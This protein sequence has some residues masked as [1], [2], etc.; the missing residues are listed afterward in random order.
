MQELK[1]NTGIREQ[2]A[3]FAA[4]VSSKPQ[5]PDHPNPIQKQVILPFRIGILFVSVGAAIGVAVMW[6][7]ITLWNA[8]GAVAFSLL[9]ATAILLGVATPI[10]IVLIVDTIYKMRYQHEMQGSGWGTYFNRLSAWKQEGRE[11]FT[12][13][14]EHDSL[15]RAALRY[16]LD[17]D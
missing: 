12:N 15:T 4:W 10:G 6:I 2:K 17:F 9:F 1:V 3:Q 16:H 11:R 7:G 14:A 8:S 13:L 5:K